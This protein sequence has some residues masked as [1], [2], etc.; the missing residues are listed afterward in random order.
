MQAVEF[1]TTV[2]THTFALMAAH[3]ATDTA[4]RTIEE[5]KAAREHARQSQLFLRA[6]PHEEPKA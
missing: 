5:R 4:L 1:I 6:F 3:T 2:V